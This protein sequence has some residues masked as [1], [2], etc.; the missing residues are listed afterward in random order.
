[1]STVLFNEGKFAAQAQSQT[2]SEDPNAAA[3]IHILLECG[4][5]NHTYFECFSDC[6]K[7][8]PGTPRHRHRTQAC[9]YKPIFRKQSE[10]AS[11]YVKQAK[12]APSR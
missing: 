2:T 12:A 7:C 10:I 4:L 1:M 6:L 11:K 9:V 5:S 3:I 8:P